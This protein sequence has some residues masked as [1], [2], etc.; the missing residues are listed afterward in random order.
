[1]IGRVYRG[2][3]VGGLLRYLYGPGGHNEHETPRLV[4]ARDLT[5]AG[6]PATL[7]PRVLDGSG[8][9]TMQDFAPMTGTLELATAFRL[10]TDKTAAKVVWHCPL[11]TSPGDRCRT[12]DE[13][14]EVARDVLHRTGTA[15]RGEDGECRWIAGRYDDVSVHPVAVRI[16]NDYRHLREACRGRR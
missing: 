6:E 3:Q 4:V 13:W 2:G 14:A 7:E 10:L 8:A 5:A 15:Q 9:R 1:M 12:E 16:G 11:R